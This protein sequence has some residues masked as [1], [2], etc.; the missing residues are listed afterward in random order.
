MLV[1]K[2][3]GGGGRTEFV[4]VCVCVGGGV[5]GGGGRHEHRSSAIIRRSEHVTSGVKVAPK[6]R[7]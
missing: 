7:R 2:R 3:W 6:H 5:A 1:R 4:C